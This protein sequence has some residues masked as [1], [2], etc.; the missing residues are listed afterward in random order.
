MR[1]VVVVNENYNNKS[2][3][4]SLVI[5]EGKSIIMFMILLVL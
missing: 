2:I 3:V 4:I 1:T 5:D